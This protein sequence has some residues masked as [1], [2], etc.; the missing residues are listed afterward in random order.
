MKI[1]R[2][3]LG[4]VAS[5]FV[6]TAMLAALTAMPASAA[7]AIGGTGTA[8]AGDGTPL[9]DNKLSFTSEL[10]LP[11]GVSVPDATFT[12]TL[13]GANADSDPDYSVTNGTVDVQTGTGSV[14][15]KA[16]FDKSDDGNLTDSGKTGIKKV[17]E[18]VTLDLSGLPKFTNVG[19]YK[20]TLTQSLNS[21]LSDDF[22]LTKITDRVVY[23][24]VARTNDNPET[25]SVTGAVM[26]NKD[27]YDATAKS[28]GTI[29]NF[30]LVNGNPD[31]PDDGSNPP[32]VQQ[33][34]LTIS[35]AIEGAMGDKTAEFSFEFTVNSTADSTK[36]F[37][38]IV[39]KDN[40][41][42]TKQYAVSG[43]KISGIELGDG[44]TIT[45]Y[46]L[47]SNDTFDVAQTNHDVNGYDT[48]IGAEDLSGV[49]DKTLSDYTAL[50]FTN[51]RD[52]ITPTGVVMNVAPY[53]LLVVVAAAAGFVFLR[54]RRED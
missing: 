4:R 30:Y 22:N 43:T 25:Y 6:A 49:T 19:V 21:K 38:Y 10:W 13:T 3:N 34:S 42:G 7:S 14:E 46:G 32:Q 51:T 50:N 5:A 35:N 33:N 47:S 41:P 17:S 20:Y 53:L 23:L 29:T 28:K 48:K 24:F 37:A 16:E 2:K 26:V 44:D 1:S 36:E 40:V 12:Y 45:I 15:G 18:T 31:N 9:N 27:S 39:T 52:A 8:G 54:K 11:E